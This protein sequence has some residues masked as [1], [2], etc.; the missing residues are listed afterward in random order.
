MMKMF[1]SRTVKCG[2]TPG[3]LGLAHDKKTIKTEDRTSKCDCQISLMIFI[4]TVP[5]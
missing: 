3:K 5:N 1:A 4:E 2:G